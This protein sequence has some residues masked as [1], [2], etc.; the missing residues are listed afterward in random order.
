MANAAPISVLIL[1]D[2]ADVRRILADHL[3]DEGRFEVRT[4][5][6]GAE[7]L[8]VLDAAPVDVCLVDLRLEGTD[9]FVFVQ[10]ARSRHPSVRFLI[11]T[12]SPLEDVRDRA[13]AAG[14]TEDHILLK[15][16]PLSTIVRTIRRVAAR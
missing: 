6:T 5:E 11:H 10:E 2:E 1:D 14:L 12:G 9:G 15:P 8:A 4:A 3:E 7:A 16:L 13:R